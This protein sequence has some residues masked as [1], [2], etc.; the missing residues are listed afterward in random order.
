M[1]RLYENKNI[2]KELETYVKNYSSLHPY[3]ELNF[4]GV[5]P[6]NYCGFISLN[7]ESYFIA[8]KI[9]NSDT[10]NLDIFIYMLIYAYDINL[11]NEDMSSGSMSKSHLIELFIRFFADT[12]LEELKRG[13][14]REYITLEDNLKVLRGKYLI[15]KNFSNFYHQN[16]YCEYDEFS[17]DSELNRLFLYA[18]KH[19]QK[20]S[21]YPN[22]YRCEAL[23][24][25]VSHI[26]VDF[27]NTNIRFNRVNKR[28]ENSYN[29]AIMLLQK[30]IPMTKNAQDRSFAFLFN[31]AEVFEKFVGKMYMELDNTTKLQLQKDFGNLRLKPDIVTSTTIID[32]KYKMLQSRDD[33]STQDKYQAFT[34]GVNFKVKDT[35]LLYPKHLKDVDDNLKLGKGESLIELKLKSLD[36]SFDG[37]YVEFIDEIR[38]RIKGLKC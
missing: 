15:S 11:K 29:I 21:S 12:L 37:G 7:G 22:L 16:I 8:P 36:L 6:K 3:F 28:Y 27:E 10:H 19:L 35:M 23:L 26:N 2:P 30:L 17:M 32:T 9:T 38:E 1:N 34:Y 4:N 24:D 13:I 31:M 20:F 25:E 18:I 33:L 14:L 5:K